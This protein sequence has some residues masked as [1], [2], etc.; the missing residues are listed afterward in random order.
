M[1]IT[2]HFPDFRRKNRKIGPFIRVR[3]LALDAEQAVARIGGT[4]LP[5]FHK[6]CFFASID[7]VACG[8]AIRR[9]LEMSLPVTRH[10][11]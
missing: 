5:E 6:R 2:N 10:I 11:P 9:S 3:R 4:I 8:T 1:L 7:K